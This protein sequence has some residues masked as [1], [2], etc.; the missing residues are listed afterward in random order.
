MNLLIFTTVSKWL[1]VVDC[2]ISVLFLFVSTSSS[3][4][5]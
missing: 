3:A 4:T 1:F 5:T 2:F